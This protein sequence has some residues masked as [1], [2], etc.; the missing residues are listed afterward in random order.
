MLYL[1]L[2]VRAAPWLNQGNHLWLIIIT[3]ISLLGLIAL[4]IFKKK[5]GDKWLELYSLNT[6]YYGYTTY[7][8]NDYYWSV[9]D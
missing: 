7:I 5:K 3:C 9:V 6:K 1:L 4:F 2:D 8:F